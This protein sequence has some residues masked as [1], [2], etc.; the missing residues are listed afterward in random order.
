VGVIVNAVSGYDLGYVWTNQGAQGQPEATAGGYYINAAQ[1]GEPPGLWWGPGA[2]AF[3]FEPGQVVDRTPYEQVYRQIDP[4]TGEKLGRSQGNYAKFADH[5]A[6]LKAAEPHAT[7]ERLLQLEREAAKATK[8]AA[9]YTDMTASFSKSMSVLHASIRENGRRARLAGDE[10]GA[11][12]WDE[13]EARYQAALQAA[14]RAG[15]E[16]V[17]RW[18]GMTRTG[19]HAAKVGGQEQGRFEEALI[20]VSSWLQGTSRDGDPQDHI[21][22]QIARLVKTVKDGEHRA[23]DTV[24]LRQV[25][26]TIQAV[27]ATHAECGLT[28]EF[29]VEW[30]PRTD[31][32]GNEIEGIT[33]AQMDAFSSRTE[34]ITRELPNAAAAW[35]RKY[36]REPNRRELLYIRQEVTLAT[37]AHKQEGAIDWDAKC[38]AWGAKWDRQFSG[39][40]GSVA[41]SVSNLRGAENRGDAKEG[42]ATTYTQVT[43]ADLTRATQRALVLVQGKQSTWTRADLMKQLALVLP[44]ETRR[45]PPAEAVALLDDLADSALAGAVEQVSCLEAPEWPP[46]PAYLRRSL[47]GRSVFTRPGTARYATRVQLSMEERLLADAQRQGAPRME[48]EE[49]AQALGADAD[50]LDAEL[51]ERAQEARA[52]ITKSGLRLD[53]SAALYHVLT[54]PRTAEVIVGPAGSGK[55]WTLAQAARAWPGRVVGVTPS[56]AASNVLSSA[57]VPN[58][59]NFAQFLG[60]TKE[61]RGTLG[62]QAKLAPGTGLILID[63]GSMLSEVDMADIL[64]YAARYGHKVIISGDQEQLAAVESGGGMML[65]ARR[66]GFVQLAEAVRFKAQW[67]REASLR[68]RAGDASVLDEYAGHGRIRGGEPDQVLEEACE[69]YVAN[70]LAGRDT[71][72]MIHEHE[73]CREASRRI[74]DDLV[75][76]GLVDDGPTVRLAEGERA[77]VGDLIICRE[78]D[79]D[80]EAG[81]RGRTLANGDA[82]RIESIEE[83]SITVRRMLDCDPETGLRRWT[84]HA[85]SYGSYGTADLAYAITGHS[86]QGRTVTFGIP[87][88]TGNE[89]RQWLYVAM[90]RGTDGNFAFTF[91]RSSKIADPKAGTRRAPELD[92]H[93]RI[94]RAR[95]GLPP[96]PVEAETNPEARAPIAAIADVHERDSS[97]ESAIETERESLAN[98]DHL[99]VLHARWE[100]ETKGAETSRYRQL[101]TENTPS[102]W[103]GVELS[104]QATWLWRTLRSAEAAGLDAKQVVQ[105]AFASGSLAGARDLASVIDARIRQRVDGLVPLPQRPWSERVPVVSAPDR[106]RFITDLAQA[107]DERKERIGEH[108]AETAPSWA[109]RALGP[110]PD[111][112]LDR[113]EWERRASSVGAYRELYAYEHPSEPIGPEPTGDSPEKRAAWHEAFAALGPADG[114]DLRGLPDGSLW[115]RRSTY[116]AETAWAPR[117]VGRELQRIRVSA[118]QAD[119]T[120]IRSQAEA[121]VATQR[122]QA[123]RAGRHAAMARSAQAME[124]VYREREAE[125]AETMEARQEWECATERTRHLAVAADS[126]LRRRHPGQKLEP[127]RSAEAVVTEEE[128]AELVLTPGEVEYTTPEWITRLAAE[129]RAVREKLEERQGVR[130]PSEDPDAQDEGEAWPTWFRRDRDAILQPPRPE[131]KPSPRVVEL[132]NERAAQRAQAT[133]EAE[134]ST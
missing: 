44:V 93:D 120:A 78:N 50:R 90:T 126:E 16:Y 71:L 1:A 122:G 132:A 84:D 15:L 72:L 129:R 127:L 48:R 28:Q 24:S 117:H 107:M 66:L 30:I 12:Y 104:R 79:H 99:A 39:D 9:A 92:R 65:L 59:M 40:L 115:H 54:S 88:I 85:F 134:V 23:L 119:T 32:K 21:H 70:Y 100:G 25:L 29:G 33:Q 130:V 60:H 121:A 105:E 3:G 112:P 106:Q 19:H 61:G 75:H 83:G 80:L 52:E 13:A 27:I 89:N 57:G 43:Q 8:Q 5:L 110:V 113:L 14:N 74:R 38:A 47:D 6:R 97:E 124:R 128:S 20:T 34:S 98:S 76:L 26:G 81:E 68:L 118:S 51:Y 102:E 125:L 36:G 63:E 64:S 4:R 58:V 91:T 62:I 31:G 69:M 41:A 77:S 55:T 82:L 22:N 109:V 86:A 10:A 111:E 49:A 114:V 101:I 103:A 87:V 42:D 45:L 7:G 53:Q 17:Q 35:A 37:R 46:V 2:E 123:E 116:A 56:Q 95:E 96:L 73:R 108:A 18:A 94:E 11:A 133:A 67:E 131:M